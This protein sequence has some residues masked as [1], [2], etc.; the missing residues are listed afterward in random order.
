MQ[1]GE[2]KFREH[3]WVQIPTV[4]L[5]VVNT[6]TAGSIS[7]PLLS[8]NHQ[9]RHLVLL[10]ICQSMHQCCMV[11]GLTLISENQQ[12]TL[13]FKNGAINLITFRIS[14][15]IFCLLLISTCLVISLHLLSYNSFADDS[16]FSLSFL[17]SHTRF[18]ACLAD[19][20]SPRAGDISFQHD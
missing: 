2:N 10:Q 13:F 8:T 20:S 9:I 12:T 7:L 3:P 1:G 16:R 6:A 4:V 19:I 15:R 18:S 14:F 17:P 5:G 11:S